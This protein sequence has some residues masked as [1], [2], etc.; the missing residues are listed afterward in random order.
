MGAGGTAAQ[1]G[2]ATTLLARA[3]FA[4]L[5]SLVLLAA[6]DFVLRAGV[7]LPFAS[8]SLVAGATPRS[9]LLP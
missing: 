2:G 3:A 1:C 8:P 9:I 4:L 6:V 7:C 5:L